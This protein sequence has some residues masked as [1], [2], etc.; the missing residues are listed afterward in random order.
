MPLVRPRT[1][2]GGSRGRFS[3][4]IPHV[5]SIKLHFHPRAAP[6]ALIVTHW[7]AIG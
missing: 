4:E 3:V 1:K 6:E 2:S 7:V 5:G